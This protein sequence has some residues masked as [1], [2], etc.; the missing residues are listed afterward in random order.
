VARGAGPELYWDRS[1][2]RLYFE[3][4]PSRGRRG[5][6]P[7]FLSLR[8]LDLVVSS[9][10]SSWTLANTLRAS[11]QGSAHWQSGFSPEGVG[12]KPSW[13][14]EMPTGASRQ[15]RA[16]EFTNAKARSNWDLSRR[17]LIR[18]RH[19]WMVACDRLGRRQIRS[20]AL[21]LVDLELLCCLNRCAKDHAP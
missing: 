11:E 20:M 1:H 12:E 17:A 10:Q 18:C 8:Q 16:T 4:P 21:G 2:E 9:R 3:Y 5:F 14:D 19:S 13:C 7:Q 6:R 15:L